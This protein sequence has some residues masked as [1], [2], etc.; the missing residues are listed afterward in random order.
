MAVIPLFPETKMANVSKLI[1]VGNL[2]VRK[3]TWLVLTT[4][5]ATLI[6]FFRVFGAD[7]MTRIVNIYS[8]LPS[9]HSLTL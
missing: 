4:T 9:T 5:S 8:R 1:N 2:L 7:S 6:F 3:V